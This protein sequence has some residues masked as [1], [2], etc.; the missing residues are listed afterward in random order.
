MTVI[1]AAFTTIPIP[2]VHNYHFVVVVVMHPNM[3][4]M[5]VLLNSVVSVA[6]PFINTITMIEVAA[7]ALI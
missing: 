4:G 6:M 3:A 7:P 5:P 1:E 2:N